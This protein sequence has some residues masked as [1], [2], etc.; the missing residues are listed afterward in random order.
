[1]RAVMLR[2]SECFKRE[3]I[4]ALE[5]GQFSSIEA[6]RRH[7]GIKGADTVPRWLKRVGRQDLRTKVVRVEKPGERD[8]ISEL[9]KQVAQLQRALGQTQAQNL[10]NE[11]LLKTAC[12]RLGEDVEA[13]KKKSGG[14]PCTGSS[15]K[16]GGA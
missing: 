6:L 4:E 14:V 2:Y 11:E 3:V 8:R 5:S 9:L 13:F 7:Y 16:D 15:G 1:V 12:G 10:L